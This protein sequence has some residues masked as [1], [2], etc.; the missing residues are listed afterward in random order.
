MD[1]TSGGVYFCDSFMYRVRLVTSDGKINSFVGY[2]VSTGG[3]T[4]STGDGGM[5][6]SALVKT[7][8]GMQFIYILKF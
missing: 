1:S 5:A 3:Q 4:G 8:K 7:P 2:A 6:S